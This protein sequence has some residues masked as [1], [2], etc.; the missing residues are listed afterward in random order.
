M[1]SRGLG[2]FS[3]LLRGVASRV[4]AG[5]ARSHYATN[6]RPRTFGRV[7]CH[8]EKRMSSSSSGKSEVDHA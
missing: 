6:A 3:S 8:V 2:S 4:A 7:Y 5:P 1:I